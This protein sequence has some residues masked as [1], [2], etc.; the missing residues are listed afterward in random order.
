[1]QKRGLRVDSGFCWPPEEFL[2]LVFLIFSGLYRYIKTPTIMAIPPKRSRSHNKFYFLWLPCKRW[3]FSIL[4]FPRPRFLVHRHSF[5]HQILDWAGFPL[6]GL[7]LL[8]LVRI[9]GMA[10]W[11][12]AWKHN[13]LRL[14]AVARR[15]LRVL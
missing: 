8:L 1:V 5:A 4:P 2:H 13:I 9:Q 7:V 15:L 14:V 10:A 12:S 11:V 6:V 3:A